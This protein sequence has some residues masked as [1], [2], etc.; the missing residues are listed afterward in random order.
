MIEGAGLELL[1]HSRAFK[2][3][4]IL[5]PSVRSLLAL[6]YMERRVLKGTFVLSQFVTKET[7]V[8]HGCFSGKL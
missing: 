2:K 7:V 5:L 1:R 8:I 6:V 4:R 3:T